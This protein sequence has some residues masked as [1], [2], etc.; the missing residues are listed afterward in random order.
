MIKT[1]RKKIGKKLH[2]K[3]LKKLNKKTFKK[4]HK[5]TLKKSKLLNGGIQF[6]IN[7]RQIEQ[8]QHIG[9][10][11]TPGENISCT[12]CSL[13][14]I[15]FPK[16]LVNFVSDSTNRGVHLTTQQIAHL[17]GSIQELYFRN[18][19]SVNPYY[20][21]LGSPQQKLIVTQ[22]RPA[23]RVN[24]F[25]DII[26]TQNALQGIFEIMNDG[27][28]TLLLITFIDN[29]RL[30][31]HIVVIAK[32][33]R[34]TP[35]LIETQSGTSRLQN[36]YRS[37]PDIITNYFN[38]LPQIS[39]FTTFNSTQPYYDINSKK[40]KLPNDDPIIPLLSRNLESV[41]PLRFEFEDLRNIDPDRHQY[42]PAIKR[43]D[44]FQSLASTSSP[45][46][47]PDTTPRPT[48]RQ[49]DYT[50]VESE[51]A[52]L[53]AALAASR[54]TARET[55]REEQELRDVIAASRETARETARQE[56]ERR[57]EEQE[58]RDVIAASLAET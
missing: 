54:E 9:K 33:N 53:A 3:T 12:A 31:S 19:P 48:P 29:E 18:Y 38:R 2:K 44:S 15:G 7:P 46:P 36:V 16:S 4:L 45:A 28:S 25:T 57:R 5:K 34:G 24:F 20:W 27:A 39:Y 49:P 22:E 6:E 1:K 21:R 55:V 35:Y 23:Y 40:W 17:L 13:N 11:G 43:S 50:V 26:M 8:L 42:V 37:M 10:R 52:D 30:S 56:Q 32:S 51:D 41:D 47:S 14:Q 58:L